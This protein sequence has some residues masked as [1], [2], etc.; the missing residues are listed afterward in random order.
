MKMLAKIISG[1]AIV[2]LLCAPLLFYNNRISQ[3]QTNEILLIS[4]IIWF[5]SA[6]FWMEVKTKE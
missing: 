4:S 6:P 3:N 5:L 1:I 2:G